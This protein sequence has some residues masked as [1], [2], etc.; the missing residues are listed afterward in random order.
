[1][2]Q[3]ANGL[4]IIDLLRPLGV[5]RKLNFNNGGTHPARPVRVLHEDV[6]LIKAGISCSTLHTWQKH[7]RQVSAPAAVP[8]RSVGDT[9]YRIREFSLRFHYAS[10]IQQPPSEVRLS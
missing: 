10:S 5:F 8:V 6:N 7:E 1:M 9:S 3:S 2:C 4:T